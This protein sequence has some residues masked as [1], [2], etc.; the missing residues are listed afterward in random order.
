MIDDTV[1]KRAASVAPQASNCLATRRG[2][3]NTAAQHGRLLIE[4]CKKL[5]AYEKNDGQERSPEI[6]DRRTTRSYRRDWCFHQH[7]IAAGRIEA[8]ATNMNKDVTPPP[9]FAFITRHPTGPIIAATDKGGTKSFRDLAS[10]G[11]STLALPSIL[12]S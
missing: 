7:L 1:A 3:L 12:L 8:M 2:D 6:T 9:P 4:I 11:D 10:C 5:P